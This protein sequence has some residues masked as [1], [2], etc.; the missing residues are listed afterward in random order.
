MAVVCFMNVTDIM[1]QKKKSFQGTVKFSIKY[2]GDIDPQELANA[3]TEASYMI[4]GNNTKIS[5]D[6][7]GAFRYDITVG[8]SGTMILL[9]DIPTQKIAVAITKE[10]MQEAQANIKFTVTPSTETKVIC[11]YTC[12]KYDITVGNIEN[13]S[14]Q[15][16][17]VYT[18]E[19]IGL[20][21]K[22][23]LDIPGL[24]GYPLYQ[25]QGNEKVKVITEAV[26]VKKKKISPAEFMIPEGYQ[27]MTQEEF[28]E[29]VEKMQ[30]GGQGGE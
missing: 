3:P 14:E 12:K 18:T 24:K 26:E 9:F 21:E 20:N 28:Q 25:E 8:D 11:G 4:A 16:M 10:E 6:L 19:E 13:E 30:S 17:V 2:E 7:G 1:A 27:K 23:N 29:F 22:I 15:K 5:R